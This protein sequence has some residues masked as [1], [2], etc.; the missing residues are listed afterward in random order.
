MSDQRLCDDQQSEEWLQQTRNNLHPILEKILNNP[1][2]H[3]KVKVEQVFMIERLLANC[4]T[5]L[6]PSLP[7]LIKKLVQYTA[8]ERPEVKEEALKAICQLDKSQVKFD[9]AVRQNLYDVV[10]CLPRIV[11]QGSKSLHFTLR[12]RNR[13]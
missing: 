7:V 12:L 3:W 11:S 1:E 9:S 13:C 2:M 5:T 10:T 6:E 8:D 4:H